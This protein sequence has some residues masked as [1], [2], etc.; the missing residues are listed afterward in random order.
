MSKVFISYSHKDVNWKDRVVKQLSVLER[1]GKLEIWDDRRIAGGDDWLPEIKQAMQ[2]CDVALLLISADFLT[3]GF[4]LGTEVPNLL[5]RGVKEGI[6]VIPLIL[7]PCAWTQVTW[8]S[9]IQARPIDGS[10]LSSLSKNKAEAALSA[11]VEEVLHLTPRNPP[12]RDCIRP[13][14]L[15]GNCRHFIG[16]KAEL[17]LL[18][19]GTI[20]VSP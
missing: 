15:R 2:E 13:S 9:G 5:K 16:R 20:G 18:D 6:R 8:L 4:I 10:P 11:L 7:W 3:S 19:R 14:R 1:E 12:K 17:E